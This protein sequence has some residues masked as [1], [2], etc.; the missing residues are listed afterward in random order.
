M[1]EGLFL[2]W[3]LRDFIT[4]LRGNVHRRGWN[5]LASCAAKLSPYSHEKRRKRFPRKAPKSANRLPTPVVIAPSGNQPV[6]AGSKARAATWPSQTPT[7]VAAA[8]LGC[9]Q[10]KAVPPIPG[11]RC[12]RAN[13]HPTAR[14]GRLAMAPQARRRNPRQQRLRTPGSPRG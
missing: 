6:C 10:V 7:Y 14:A 5:R 9:H 2:T 11:S 8:C 3:T 12:R 13:L 4:L 1:G